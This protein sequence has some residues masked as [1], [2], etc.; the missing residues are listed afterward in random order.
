M[1]IAIRRSWAAFHS[2]RSCAVY[3]PPFGTDEHEVWQV[4]QL[5][6]RDPV[7]PS[8]T[9]V[10]EREDMGL[11]GDIDLILGHRRFPEG[12][13]A[14]VELAPTGSK[15]PEHVLDGMLDVSGH[16]PNPGYSRLVALLL[17]G[18]HRR[19]DPSVRLTSPGR[20]TVITRIQIPY[21]AFIHRH[22]R[23]P[24]HPSE[25]K[26]SSTKQRAAERGL[27]PSLARIDNR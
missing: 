23:P 8:R 10:A 27:T 15:P 25:S 11:L 12:L 1:T 4:V 22:E 14:P 19:S 13:V 9:V 3:L 5:L 18:T 26:G 17:A 16:V 7:V 24:E 2:L 21:F 20:L 6:V